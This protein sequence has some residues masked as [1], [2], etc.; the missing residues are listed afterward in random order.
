[1][2]GRAGPSDAAD[3]AAVAGR[4]LGRP[5]GHRAPERR[6][7]RRAADPLPEGRRRG[8]RPDGLHRPG[9]QSLPGQ[10]GV[11]DGQAAGLFRHRPRQRPGSAGRQARHRPARR[12]TGL[13]P[14]VAQRRLRPDRRPGQGGCARAGEA[15][16]GI[17]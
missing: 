8:D 13:R 7:A 1:Y 2:P 6:P 15:L 10:D 17:G 16:R 5:V 12:G 3:P 11:R 9:A 14:G 4:G